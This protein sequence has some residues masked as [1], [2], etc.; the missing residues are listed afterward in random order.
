VSQAAPKPVVLVVEDDASVRRALAVGLGAE[1]MRALEATTV[2]AAIRDL[3]QYVPDVL[4]LDLGLPDGDGLEVLRALRRWSALP[5]IVLS[6]RGQEPQK[7]AA[8]DA[9]ADDYVTKPFGFPEL[10]ARVRAALRRT[11]RAPASATSVFT[12]GPL[13]ADL[14]RREV[15][16]GGDPVALT[17]TEFKLLAV[18]VRHADRVVTHAALAR[19][20]WGPGAATHPSLRVHMTN[21][22]RKLG[23]D[24]RA[25]S[26]IETLVGVGYRLRVE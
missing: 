10:V 9:G 21:L 6:A 19:E 18:L 7:V 11:S 1:G 24:P 20:L 26:P 15:Q 2:A 5:A 14:E 23:P 25:P 13:T 22:R 17:A 3:E 8:L 16:V 4:L 12:A